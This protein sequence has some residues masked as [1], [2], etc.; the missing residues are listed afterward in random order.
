M[1]KISDPVLAKDEPRL[2]KPSISVFNLAS[3]VRYIEGKLLTIVEA[4]MDE[5]EKKMATKSLVRNALWDTYGEI[6]QW[7]I[8]QTDSEKSTFPIPSN[9]VEV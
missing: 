8:S 7:G 2:K 5:K 6:Y 1:S 4:T 3:F 9:K